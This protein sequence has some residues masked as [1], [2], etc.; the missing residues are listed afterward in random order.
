MKYFVC[1]CTFQYLSNG[2]L[3][4]GTSFLLIHIWVPKKS[5]AGDRGE[6]KVSDLCNLIS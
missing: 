6:S 4:L 2:L 5:S 1:H 3:F